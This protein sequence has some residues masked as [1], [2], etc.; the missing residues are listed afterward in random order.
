[1]SIPNILNFDYFANVP[2]KQFN[3]QAQLYGN[4][5]SGHFLGKA[6]FDAIIESTNKINKLFP[7]YSK[8]EFVP[9][10]GSLANERAIMDQLC[11]REQ[12]RSS[13]R[14]IIMMS[15]IEHSSIRKHL[16]H[17]LNTKGYNLVIIPATKD[18]IINLEIFAKQLNE[19]SDKLAIISCMFVNN[20]IGT[21]QPILEMVKLAKAQFNDVIFHSDVSGSVGEFYKLLQTCEENI[22]VPDI[23][24]FSAYKFGGPH[25]GIV[26]T[27]VK[28]KPKYYGTNDVKNIL[29]TTNAL[30]L[31]LTEYDSL[32]QHNT[33]FKAQL[34]TTLFELFELHKIT[35]VDLDVPTSTV[36][37]ILSFVLPGLK[38]SFIQQKLSE[39]LIAIGSGS[40]CTT[41]EGSS[42]ILAMGYPPDIAQQLIRLSF[43]ALDYNNDQYINII[44]ILAN[45]IIEI[46]KSHLFL[47]KK[48]HKIKI[49]DQTSKTILSSIRERPS[50]EG[51]LDTPIKP[52]MI[53]K[54]ALVFAEIV[55]KGGN[56]EWFVTKLKICVQAKV[57]QLKTNLNINITVNRQSKNMFHVEFVEPIENHHPNLQTIVNQLSLTAGISYV[58]PMTIIK[59]KNPEDMCY[60]IANVYDNIRTLHSTNARSFKV[61]TTITNNKYLN[62]GG[63]WWS[64]YVGNF[65]TKKYVDPVNLSNPDITLY[66]YYDGK[67]FYSYNTKVPGMGGLPSNSEGT[68]M[69]LVTVANYYRSIYAIYNMAKRGVTPIVIIDNTVGNATN[70]CN[71]MFEQLNKLVKIITIKGSVV[72]KLETMPELKNYIKSLK[73]THLVIEIS[74]HVILSSSLK[75][76][77]LL[78]AELGLNCFSVSTLVEDTEIIKF[79]KNLETKVGFNFSFVEKTLNI[80]SNDTFQYLTL[81]SNNDAIPNQHNNGLVLVS[82]GIDSPVVSSKLKSNNIY[83]QYV[84]FISRL[85][86]SVSKQK[87]IGIVGQIGLDNKIIHFVEFEK[88]Q[89]EIAKKYKESYRVMLYKIFMVIIA[90]KIAKT[91]NLSFIA[92]GNAWGQVASQTPDNLYVTDYFSELPILCPLISENKNDIIVSATQTKT[93]EKSICNGNDCCTTFLPDSP[94]LNA[95]K[96]YIQRV[97]TELDY[98]KFISIETISL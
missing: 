79:V 1:M 69:F 46:V 14:N 5:H 35:Y 93:F 13:D 28:L 68:I 64:G 59:S 52:V 39:K 19:Y 66:L 60:E 91:N 82:G 18:G 44:Q 21:V 3:S 16:A 88:L 9:G 31:Y 7:H 33:Q 84:N 62:H 83:H 71:Y 87:I 10:G 47:I 56:F 37:N 70:E 24:T 40:A 94:T 53:N 30:E 38:S 58:I 75:M 6:A 97:I 43:N 67:T 2:E 48:Q 98:E 77:K 76:L 63:T 96:D 8:V 17:N 74:Q 23:V 80:E 4:S 41:N 42:T 86:D 20:E 92:M 51:K 12:A 25:Y 89:E 32:V 72:V 49:K 54:I 61:A 11:L 73:R 27:N 85:D 90:N 45:E 55:T 81:L 34:K 26:L 15:S 36:S 29:A 57:H 22:I 78:G 95:N 50:F 65:I